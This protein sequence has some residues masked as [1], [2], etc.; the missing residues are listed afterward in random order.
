MS[1]PRRLLP[2]LIGLLLLQAAAVPAACLHHALRGAAREAGWVVP[3]CTAEGLLLRHAPAEEGGAPLAAPEG[4]CL[5][6]HPPPQTGLPPLTPQAGAALAL[7]A[8]PT[9]PGA[10]DRPGPARW[11]AAHGPRG[12]P[13]A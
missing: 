7:A 9:M 3:I 4:G 12:P 13:L 2:V 11:P 10:P 5:A 1:R 8:P 6:C